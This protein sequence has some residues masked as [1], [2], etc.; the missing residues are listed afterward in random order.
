VTVTTR[1]PSDLQT[2]PSDGMALLW[3]P[4]CETEQ[5]GVEASPGDDISQS[6]EMKSQRVAPSGSVFLSASLAADSEKYLATL[7]LAFPLP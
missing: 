4:G 2:V 3:P 6:S 5:R 7:N 1:E